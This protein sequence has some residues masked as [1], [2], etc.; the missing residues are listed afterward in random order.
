M[1]LFRIER[2]M[3]SRSTKFV[4]LVVSMGVI[5]VTLIG[6]AWTRAKVVGV[7]FLRK[8]WVTLTSAISSGKKLLLNERSAKVRLA[9]MLTLMG[10]LILIGFAAIVGEVI[11][12]F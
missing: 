12:A 9:L 11:H 4:N 8:L 1:D 2:W 7:P 3:G 10:S 6:H 5:I